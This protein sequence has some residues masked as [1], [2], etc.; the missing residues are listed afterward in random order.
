MSK[1]IGPQ[2]WPM[3]KITSDEDSGWKW[4]TWE[5]NILTCSQ[6]IFLKSL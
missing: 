3:Q 2:V 4:V 6:C 1:G 5:I